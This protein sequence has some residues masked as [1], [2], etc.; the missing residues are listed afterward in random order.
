M[1]TEKQIEVAARKFCEMLGLDPDARVG[2]GVDVE[3][4]YTGLVPA[5]A[6]YSPQWTR[7]AREIKRAA[8]MQDAIAAALQG[9]DVRNGD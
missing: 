5:V 6:I 3:D 7:Y 9:G 2:H 8:M 4:G 1:M